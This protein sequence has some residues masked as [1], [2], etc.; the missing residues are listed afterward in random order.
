MTPEQLDLFDMSFSP[1]PVIPKVAKASKVSSV[2]NDKMRIIKAAE[3]I[4]MSACVEQIDF[5]HSILCQVGMP[6]GET[7]ELCFERKNG[8]AMILLE[9]GK[10]AH[11][12]GHWEQ[13]PLPSG[14]KPRLV[15]V[16]ITSEAVKNKT[17]KI[18]IGS[19]AREFLKTL[20]IDTGG[21]S[22][23]GFR[24]QMNALAA[25]RMTLGMANGQRSITVDAKPIEKFEAWV[26]NND[27]QS[28]LWPGELEL[29]DKFFQTMVK[30]AVPLDRRSLAALK[31]SALKLDIY[32]WLAQR[33][34]RIDDKKGI[35]LTW[36]RLKDQFGE[37][38]SRENNFKKEFSRS[39]KSVLAVYP[40]AKVS[41]V[42][43]GLLLLPS[44]PPVSKTMILIN[45]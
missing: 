41:S 12:K 19:S 15:M 31:S 30:H 16:H 7:K 4:K 18:D 28:T 33:L 39:L 34:C 40:N 26:T 1:K 10:L 27:N 45:K 5:L 43:D 36:G 24:K 14:V 32:T 38:Y 42:E 13:Q 29:S 20:G 9:A 35:V 23:E 21:H 37:E 22:Y 2:R 44:V 6:R 11:P 8:Q 3:E 17:R 25:C